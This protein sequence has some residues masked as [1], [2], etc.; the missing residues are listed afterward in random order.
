MPTRSVSGAE[1]T[2]LRL[3]LIL[4]IRNRLKNDEKTHFSDLLETKAER[5]LMWEGRPGYFVAALCFGLSPGEDL[6]KTSSSS[7][8]PSPLY[9]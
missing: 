7:A 8:R 3:K 4:I 6:G 2:H 5:R 1:L 9:K